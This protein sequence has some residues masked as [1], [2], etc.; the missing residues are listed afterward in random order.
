MNFI[1]W[2]FS[3]IRW[4]YLFA[5][6]ITI[7]AGYCVSQSIDYFIS[8]PWT[9]ALFILIM[10]GFIAGMTVHMYRAYKVS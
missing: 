6:A 4:G 3:E 7:Y 5:I 2:F 10:G 1:K 8:E 9:I